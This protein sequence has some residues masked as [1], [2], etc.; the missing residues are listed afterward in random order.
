MDAP[1]VQYVTTSDG[2]SLAYIAAGKGPA[3]LFLPFHSNHVQ[4]RW[5]GPYW[6][7]GLAERWRVV[8]YDSR[9][10]GL[11]TRN[12]AVDPS[13]ADYRRDLEAVIEAAELRRFVV[14]AYGGFAHVAVRYAAENTDRVRALVLICTCESFSAWPLTALV[15]LAE[16]NWDL[17]LAMQAQKSPPDV[18]ERWVSFQKA[19]HSQAD[20]IHMVRGF[21]SSDVSDVL[22]DL[23]PPTLLLHSQTQHWLSPEEGARFAAKIEGARIVFMDGEIEPDD[24]QGVRAI[25]SF[26]AELPA[27][28]PESGLP[29][30]ATPSLPALS[31]RQLEVLRLIAQGRTNRE[32]AE[33]LVLSPRTVERHVADLYCKIDARNRAEATAFALSTLRS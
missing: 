7:R 18:Q 31:E 2:F 20:Y 28:E 19:A 29:S 6:L 14:V 24:V 17:F 32:I 9:G 16:A 8:H 30:Y 21:S 33:Q 4:R 25:L 10:Q 27:S 5:T 22:P 11:S 26:L 1:P 23:R 3:L 12:L 13:P 15:P